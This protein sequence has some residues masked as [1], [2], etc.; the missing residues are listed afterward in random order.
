[1]L[2]LVS[3]TVGAASGVVVA[4]AAR[5]QTLVPWPD[6]IRT[7]F[8]PALGAI[9]GLGAAGVTALV[10]M[11][12]QTVAGTRPARGLLPV[13]AGGAIVA[14]GVS[15]ALANR[16][17]FLGAMFAEGRGIDPG[18]ATPPASAMVSGGPGSDIPITTLGREGARFVGSVTS[19]ADVREVLQTD[20]MHEPI[21]VFVGLDSATTVTARVAL[22]MAELRRT[23][24]FDRSYLLVMSP[25]GTGYANPVPVDVL[26]ILSGGDC[27]TVAVG[28]GLLPSFLSLDRQ[29]VGA[30]T[31]REL[32]AA[33]ASERPTATVLAYGESLGAQMQQAAVPAGVPD[34]D[35]CG[36]SRALWVGTPGGAAARRFRDVVADDSVTIDHPSDIERTDARIWF[37]EHHADPVVRFGAA[38]AVERP[39]WLAAGAER[40]RN[41]P[42]EMAW[43]PGV[44]YA[45]VFVD[46]LFATNIRPGDFQSHGHDY[47]AD[48]GATVTAAFDLPTSPA[49]ADR[50]EIRLRE[51]ERARAARILGESDPG[52]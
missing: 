26:E 36:I 22:A 34:L 52:V 35:A 47:R 18:F 40:G 17:R 44:T 12:L 51:L 28:Y 46:T 2:A 8:P 20:R 11:G 4:W 19:D 30:Q 37:L 45:Q 13:A 39:Q 43:Q 24:A 49:I 1:M 38:L 10:G 50:L 16:K 14:G 9:A 32:L 15:V 31:Q 23:G 41:V 48:L 33:I 6:K 5:G 27:A 29:A 25:A 21:R 3:T 42:A 7:V